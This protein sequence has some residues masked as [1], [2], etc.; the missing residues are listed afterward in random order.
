MI[1]WKDLQ[2]FKSHLKTE[3]P[4]LFRGIGKSWQ[5]GGMLSCS[6]GAGWWNLIDTAAKQIEKLGE[7]IQAEQ[8]KETF[9]GLRFYIQSSEA[10]PENQDKAEIVIRLIENLSFRICEECGAPGTPTRA[11]GYW[12]KTLCPSCEEARESKWKKNEDK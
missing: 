7:N 1:K 2:E 3:Y 10:S 4:V 8:I 5:D 11:G 12:I 6:C 9:G